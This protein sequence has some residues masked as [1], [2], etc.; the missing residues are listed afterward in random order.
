M[1]WL[2][3]PRCEEL[4]SL[5]AVSAASTL[6]DP[7]VKV[8]TR[9]VGQL[10]NVLPIYG[11]SI[12][13]LIKALHDP[14]DEVRSA[15]AW[16]LGRL[17]PPV[18]EAG[19]ALL[20]EIRERGCLK[21]ERLLST[22]AGIGVPPGTEAWPLVECF[23]YPELAN[24]AKSLIVQLGTAA[25]PSLMRSLGDPELEKRIK[26]YS[27][28]YGLVDEGD[29]RIGALM[30]IGPP[31]IPI[32]QAAVTDLGISTG[33]RAKAVSILAAF[34]L[35]GASETYVSDIEKAV[36]DSDPDVR[37]RAITAL[38][39][40]G[41]AAIPAMVR[42]LKSP[43][44]Q[45]CQTAGLNL[46]SAARELAVNLD[47]H[48]GALMDSLSSGDSNCQ[49]NIRELLIRTGY[50]GTEFLDALT[51]EI[52][53]GDI[54]DSWGAFGHLISMKTPESLG[55]TKAILAR[56]HARLKDR[57]ISVRL[58]AARII[59]QSESRCSDEVQGVILDALESDD[60]KIRQLVLSSLW[61][62]LGPRDSWAA[63]S[64]GRVL[65]RDDASSEIKGFLLEVLHRMGPAAVPALSSVEALEYRFQS[66]THGSAVLEVG[67]PVRDIVRALE[68]GI[69]RQGRRRSGLYRAWRS[70][71]RTIW[72][73]QGLDG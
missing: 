46:L 27:R 6:D 14:E 15:A 3:T 73:A 43:D 62:I 10:S 19:P 47:A 1:E 11:V 70:K 40:L 51:E 25:I 66:S 69:Q 7:D 60:V 5:A 67:P 50:S 68:T 36:H 57:D 34:S 39:H 55:R 52:E 49:R 63:A 72:G 42:A 22:L 45:A 37:E 4:L 26:E 65:G 20:G 56:A 41:A 32:L 12:E 21:A 44:S 29:P 64:I 54:S 61:P 2:G 17:E 9:A 53:S 16:A 8:R 59:A 28:S 38:G 18:L 71:R 58:L 33:T 23:A 48:A 13:G 30:S 35:K 24:D 31:T